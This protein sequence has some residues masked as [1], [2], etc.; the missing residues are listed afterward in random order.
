MDLRSLCLHDGR[1][2]SVAMDVEK[3]E[4]T[5]AINYFRS[6]GDSERTPG[7]LFFSGVTQFSVTSDL[8]SLRSH[9]GPGNVS[10]WTLS[11]SGATFIH[12]VGGTLAVTADKIEFGGVA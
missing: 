8:D 10:D 2:V 5:V 1:L 11:Q 6:M 7:K 4:V 9:R 12:L 3:A